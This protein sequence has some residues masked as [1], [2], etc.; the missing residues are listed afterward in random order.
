MLVSTILFGGLFGALFAGVLADR[1][2]RRRTIAMTSTLFIGGAAIISLGNS[3]EILLIG[4]FISGIGV[5][6]IS[7]AAPLYLAEVSPPHF[8]GSFV[9]LFQVCIA[10]G[11]LL[12]YG[13]SYWFAESADWRW[14]FAIGIF[15]AALQ[16]LALFFLPE[17]PAWLFSHGKETLAVETIKRFRKDKS[18]MKQIEEMKAV[19]KPGKVGR[20]KDLFSPKLRFI[21]V[22]G[23]VLSA[24]QQ[25]TG[26]NAVVYF[27]PKIFGSAGF[28]SA[29]SAIFASIFL[30]I[31]NVLATGLS[32]WLLDRVGRRVL[33]LI[34]VTGMTLSL[35]CLSIAF[36]TAS[37][38]IGA[39]SIVSLMGYIAFFAIGLGPITWVVLSEVFPLKI[40]GKAMTVAL[41]I[42][43]VCNYLIS[44][45][46]LDLVDALGSKWTFLLY[47]L[48]S[49]VA[50]WFIR[51]FI[52]E[53]RGKSL[54]EIE[55]L[56]QR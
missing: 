24:L 35:F 55:S 33:L 43:W 48:I 18:W 10:L 46:F 41:F 5:G 4:R 6:I 45:T 8:R 9:A 12:S 17:T 31:V 30:G 51:S 28:E 13:V 11:I 14:M 47:A 15:P 20:W 27:A 34:G 44:F 3:Y 22:V 54:E 25:I 1:I 53:T 42:N 49:A 36:F 16:M 37:S 40:R 21:F 29:S 19:D 32:A 26:V 7:L 23:L 56:V 50:I 38:H 39:I 2:G 52:P